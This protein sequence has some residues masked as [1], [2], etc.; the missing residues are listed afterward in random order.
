VT[1][2]VVVGVD[3]SSES[4]VALRW[5]ADEAARWAAPLE[6]VHAWREPMV[7]VPKAYPAG[8]VEM[9]RMSDAARAV[10]ARELAT[11][12]IEGDVVITPVHG[13]PAPALLERCEGAQLLVVGRHGEGHHPLL[14]NTA[15]QVARHAPC[16]VAVVPSIPEPARSK[17]IVG[18][19]GSHDAGLALRWAASEAERRGAALE[20]LLAW[21]WLDQIPAPGAP[22]FDPHYGEDEAL[23]ALE[24]AL[25]AALGAN[26]AHIERR[27]V[28]D[29]AR[30]ALVEASERA[31]VLV[32]GR[33]GA[34]GFA[35]LR[36]G[37]ISRAAVERAH[38]PVVIVRG[39]EET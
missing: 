8:L 39:P 19:D 1:G 27:A 38:C 30:V 15:E 23:L 28:C 33:R 25:N 24:A 37:S 26:T 13:R 9:G 34:G 2:A 3:A 14:G 32:T 5:A 4:R 20:A 21:S 18:V 31:D 6:V 35:G 11:A 17:V 29:L 22:D 36:L 10:V 7:F 12:G 16:P